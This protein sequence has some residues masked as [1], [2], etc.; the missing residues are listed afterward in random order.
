MRLSRFALLVTALMGFALF[1][2][3]ASCGSSSSKF[4]KGSGGSAGSSSGGDAGA[5]CLSGSCTGS[6]GTAG[7]GGAAGSAGDGGPVCVG[8]M[9]DPCIAKGMPATSVTGYVYDPAGVL[10]LYGVYVYIPSSQPAPI[11]PGN[12]A[13][14]TCEA[15]ASGGPI[16]GTLTDEHGFFNLQQGV[17][18]QYGVPSGASVPLVLQT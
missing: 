8:C 17:S 1:A 12:P 6:G 13:C 16:I 5:I 18:G 9:P 11:D 10:P 3:L 14:S 2:S 15:P 7:S 4:G